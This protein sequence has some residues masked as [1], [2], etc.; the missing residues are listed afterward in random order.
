LP[1]NLADRD[2]RIIFIRFK[3][4]DVVAPLQIIQWERFIGQE[5]VK[6]PQSPGIL[7]GRFGPDIFKKIFL[8]RLLKQDAEDF[9]VRPVI[10]EREFEMVAKRVP[11]PV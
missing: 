6:E 3:Q 10:L 7:A 11:R 5:L 2:D 4:I 1:P 9:E 8:L